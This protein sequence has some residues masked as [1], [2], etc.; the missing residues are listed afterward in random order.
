MN[1]ESYKRYKEKNKYHIWVYRDDGS[2]FVGHFK[3]RAD[4]K[5]WAGKHIRLGSVTTAS[6]TKRKRSRSRVGG[7]DS[8]FR[9]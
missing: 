9:F 4:A 7:F 5:K 1:R 6:K 3:D 8:F 2:K